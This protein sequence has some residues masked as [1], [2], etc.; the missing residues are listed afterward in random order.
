MNQ[1]PDEVIVRLLA[2]ETGVPASDV[3]TV[4][5]HVILVA[6]LM[7]CLTFPKAEIRRLVS[8]FR[9]LYEEMGKKVPSEICA[10]IV[11]P[12]TRLKIQ[13]MLRTL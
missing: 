3:D 7:K 4:T 11:R 12:D 2:D 8:G 1:P 6:Y 10:L 9:D 5:D 13:R